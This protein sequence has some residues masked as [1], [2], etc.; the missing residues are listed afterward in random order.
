MVALA[1]LCEHE[2]RAV[3][4]TSARQELS[5]SA[6]DRQHV[7]FER[8]HLIKHIRPRL[9]HRPALGHAGGVVVSRLG[10]VPL[11]MRELSF[12][13]LRGKPDLMEHGAGGCPEAVRR[14]LAAIAHTPDNL[15][16]C[17]A[18]H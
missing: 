12:D 6:S 7:A 4:L 16:Q 9:H 5:A 2:V 8:H 13:Q 14:E 11:G 17:R 3:A 15:V 18:A 10:L 1:I